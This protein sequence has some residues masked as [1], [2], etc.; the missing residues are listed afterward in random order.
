MLVI[1]YYIRDDIKNLLISLQSLIKQTAPFGLHLINDSQNQQVD[2]IIEG[3]DFSNIKDFSYL[4]SSKTITP[5]YYFNK[6]NQIGAND[7]V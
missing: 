7:Y 6:I 5:G 1:F 4:K 2:Q 3:L